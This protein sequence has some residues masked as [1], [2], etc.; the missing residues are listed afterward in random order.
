MGHRGCV[1]AVATRATVVAVAFASIWAGGMRPAVAGDAIGQVVD[2][3]ANAVA[4]ASVYLCDVQV[5]VCDFDTTTTAGGYFSF[6][7]IADGDYTLQIYPPDGLGLLSL[8]TVITVSG[9]T[10]VGPFV[11][12]SETPPPTTGS[13]DVVVTDPVGAPVSGANVLLFDSDIAG[14]AQVGSFVGELT[15]GTYSFSD[16]PEGPVVVVV[17]TLLLRPDLSSATSPSES[18]VGGETTVVPMEL[19]LR[20][21]VVGRVTNADGAPLVGAVPGISLCPL[22]IGPI[23]PPCLADPTEPDGSFAF[24]ANS[25]SELRLRASWFDGTSHVVSDPVDLILAPGVAVECELRIGGVSSCAPVT[26]SLQVTVTDTAG[27]PLAGVPVSIQAASGGSAWADPTDANGVQAVSGFPTGPYV[28]TVGPVPGVGSGT[29]TRTVAIDPS[30]T[31]IETIP[32][33]FTGIRGTVSRDEANPGATI[34]AVGACPAPLDPS[35]NGV[36]GPAVLTTGGGSGGAFTLGLNPGVPYNVRGLVATGVGG[37]VVAA[38]PSTGVTLAADVVDTCSFTTGTPGAASCGVTDDDGDG[39]DEPAG[40]DGNDDGQAD[41]G[42]HWVVS[43]EAATGGI[44]TIDALDDDFALSGV[45]AAAAPPDLPAGVDLPLGVLGFSVDLPDGASTATVRLHLP[46]G[47][48]AVAYF[49]QLPASGDWVEYPNATVV[50]DTVTLDLVDN[51]EFDHDPTVGVIGDPGGPVIGFLSPIRIG[52]VNRVKAGRT[53]PVKWRLTDENG[54]PVSEPS[55]FTGLSSVA[56]GCDGLSTGG[57]VL[58]DGSGTSGLQ[59]LGDGSW[60]YNW[61]TG[62]TWN[63]CRTLTLVL[64]NGI[65]YRAEFQFT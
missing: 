44:V 45:G 16:V 46:P 27:N 8:E 7:G 23:L 25:G 60:Q 53:V 52:A 11:L 55:S 29:V 9:E 14:A 42:Q 1:R 24:G 41:D 36:C 61:K 37:T 12:D 62:K 30:A 4:D 2:A 21:S 64:S 18:V 47:T 33:P 3:Q 39:V 20:G 26:G 31:T 5:T 63:G 10:S 58:A 6:A 38:S 35:S 40:Y 15:A 34:G 56:H 51:D 43:V 54:S 19:Q 32:L 13:V 48:D 22:A 59:H 50:G 28:V 17:M 49:K 65:T 57:S